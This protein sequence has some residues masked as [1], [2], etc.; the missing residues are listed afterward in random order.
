MMG[1]RKDTK[2]EGGKGRRRERIGEKGGRKGG[3]ERRE[4]GKGVIEGSRRERIGGKGRKI[5]KIGEKG[6]EE[7]GYWKREQED[8]KR[9]RKE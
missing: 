6:E 5:E 9:R 1:G 2:G 7:I 4:K 3:W 8:D